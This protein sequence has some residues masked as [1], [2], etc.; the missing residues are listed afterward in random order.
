LSE[1]SIR[2]LVVEDYESWRRY[3][4]T[5]L[6]KHMGLQV[7]GEVSD[8]LDAVQK[9]EELQPDLILL[10]I[11]LP[12]L[13]GIEAARRIRRVSPDSKI[14]FVSEN[15]SPDVA[16]E[17]LNA[18]AVG[19]VLKSDS[20]SEL[21]PGIRAVLEGKRFISASLAGHFLV[22]ATLTTQTIVS[23]IVMLISGLH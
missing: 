11:G 13:N 9:A 23:S 17:A 16:E 8:G 3:L 10:D 18:G 15:R 21:L 12:R 20:E 6:L 7:I 19:Y 5:L 22:A 2:V 14:L 4:S 1:P